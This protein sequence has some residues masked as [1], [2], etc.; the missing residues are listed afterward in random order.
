MAIEDF[1]KAI[2]L[3]VTQS[4]AYQLRG[5]SKYHLKQYTDAIK[6]FE[7]ATDR[8]RELIYNDGSVKENP[9]IQ[10]GLGLC[11]HALG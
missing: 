8:Q 11:Y 3:E 4:E 9:A 7:E 1:N 5:L 2:E 10:E 6:D